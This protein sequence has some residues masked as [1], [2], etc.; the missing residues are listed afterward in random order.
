MASKRP[1]TN[2]WVHAFDG[3]WTHDEQSHED[4][5]VGYLCLLVMALESLGAFLYGMLLF[6]HLALFSFGGFCVGLSTLDVGFHKA[7]DTCSFTGLDV[8]ENVQGKVARA[9]HQRKWGL[10]RYSGMK[11]GP[12]HIRKASVYV[13]CV[14]FTSGAFSSLKEANNQAAML[15]FL[16]FSSGTPQ[17]SLSRFCLFPWKVAFFSV[18][19]LLGMMV[20]RL[21]IMVL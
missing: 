14:S 13:N 21:G 4:H 20:L 6:R 8:G 5:F 16:S 10:P 11:D 18:F 15:A 1:W 17:I 19:F 12:D 7:L 2:L 3:T 9:G